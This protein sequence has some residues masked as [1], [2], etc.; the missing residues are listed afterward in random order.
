MTRQKF[1]SRRSGFL[2][3]LRWKNVDYS[4][5]FSFIGHPGCVGL[6]ALGEVGEIFIASGKPTSGEEALARDALIIASH[7]LQRG[8]SLGELAASLPQ[9][10]DGTKET[11]AA[12]IID[13]VRDEAKRIKAEWAAKGDLI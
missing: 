9:A 4:A 8:A 6:A 13:K 12:A 1:E 3:H 2:V 5:H 11:L 10:H 7:A